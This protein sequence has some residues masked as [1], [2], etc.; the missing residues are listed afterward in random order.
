[1]SQFGWPGDATKSCKLYIYE[2]TDTPNLSVAT[3]V[4]DFTPA[5]M[6]SLTSSSELSSFTKWKQESFDI[7]SFAGKTI[8]ICFEISTQFEHSWH[9]DSLSIK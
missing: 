6:Q 8:R 7:S 5:Y 9:I 2:G 3:E 4:F 1:M